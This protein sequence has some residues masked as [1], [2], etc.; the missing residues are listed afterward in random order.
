MDQG[1]K[2]ADVS[3]SGSSLCQQP[4]CCGPALAAELSSRAGY[5]QLRPLKQ[6]PDAKHPDA[7]LA[8]V[9]STLNSGGNN[10]W[11]GDHSCGTLKT[12]SSF[13]EAKNKHSPKAS[14]RAKAGWNI[15]SS[16]AKKLAHAGA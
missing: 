5:S 8:S 14:R 7:V 9:A 4:G 2:T 12:G 1:G 3:V 10:Q 16:G 15:R 6:V 11:R 13:L